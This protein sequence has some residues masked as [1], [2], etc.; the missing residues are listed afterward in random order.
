MRECNTEAAG[1]M[2]KKE[3]EMESGR[4]KAK[5]QARDERNGKREGRDGRGGLSY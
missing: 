3:G 5:E 4:E 2:L 1:M